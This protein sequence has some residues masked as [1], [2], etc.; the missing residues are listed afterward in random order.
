M[1]WK[2]TS[3]LT[4]AN[5]SVRAGWL[6]RGWRA[7]HDR[8]LTSGRCGIS[9]PFGRPVDP[10]VNITYARSSAVPVRVGLPADIPSMAARSASTLT[11]GT[12]ASANLCANAALVTQITAPLSFTMN[13]SRSSGSV[14]SSGE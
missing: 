14:E 11:T 10:E 3:K 13:C 12:M 2:E 4:G 5:C 9:T 6:R 7:C 8:R 1:S